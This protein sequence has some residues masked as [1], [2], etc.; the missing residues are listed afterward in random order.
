[1]VCI[2]ALLDKL[3]ET[4]QPRLVSNGFVCWLAYAQPLPNNFFQSLADMGGWSVVEDTNQSLW[5]FP[6]PNVLPGLG[7]LHNWARLHPMSTAITVFE[8][9]LAIDDHLQQSIRLPSNLLT[10]CV[11]YPKR[12]VIHVS[13]KLREL[14]R[15]MTN[16]IFKQ[17]QT[18]R[19][20][21]GEWFELEGG[22]LDPNAYTQSW[23]W[24]IRPQKGHQDKA[25]VKGW[26]NYGDRLEALFHQLKIPYLKTEDQ[27]LVLKISS[28]R[29]L[30]QFINKLFEF[31]GD[32][33]NL[34]WPCQYMGLEIGSHSFSTEFP[35]KVRHLFDPLEIGA[36][37]LSL[38]TVFQI[39]NPQIIPVDSR[40]SLT[41]SKI[42]DLYQIQLHPQAGG[43]R[44]G[45]LNIFL[46]SALVSG[47]EY[48]CFYC[49][50][51]SHLPANCPSRIL[52]PGNIKITALSRLGRINLDELPKILAEIEKQLSSNI[53]PGL[54]NLLMEKNDLGNV[55]AS[56]FE[57]NMICQ[58]RMVA[59]VLRAKG[60]EWPHGIENLRPQNEEYLWDAFNALR[61]GH[62]ER[63]REKLD[64][65]VLQS[66][67]S[68]QVRVLYG[69]LALERGEPRRAASF[70]EEAER[71][72]YT[73]LQ[74]SYLQLLRARLSETSNNLAEAMRLYDRAYKNSPGLSQARYRQA[75][76]MV[77]SGYLNEAQATMRDLIEGD[78]D[79][80]SI[81]LLD[82]ELEPARSF[83]L[84]DLWEIWD[85]VQTKA[86]EIIGAV[87]H[88]PDLL[89]SWL[90]PDHNNYTMLRKRIDELNTH[91]GINNY[92]ATARL[93][94]GAITI[95]NEIQAKV[96]KD[97]QKL[98]AKRKLMQKRL[99]KIRREASWF[100]FPAMLGRFTRMF[101][102][103]ADNL[104]NL[105]H[106]DL[107]VPSRFRQGHEIM[108]SAENLLAK[109]EKKLL[110]LQVIRNSILY[111]LLFFRYFIGYEI[112][113]LLLASGLTL[114]LNFVDF[115]PAIMGRTFSQ[116]KLAIFN[117]LLIVLSFAAMALTAI[118]TTSKFEKHKERILN[119][120]SP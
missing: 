108:R 89:T 12:L 65:F 94:Q 77:K 86:Q 19:G 71:L 45:S 104:E 1:M 21:T 112:L 32:T 88:L 13:D 57:I 51:R 43:K 59:M 49:G 30:D 103:C 76:C 50:L 72:A 27:A 9:S 118:T 106:M 64:R 23:L 33:Q 114:S 2:K 42:T 36:L 4:G 56:L 81:V 8:S 113:A 73:G 95:R 58:L 3:P 74:R 55:V 101:N 61:L 15:S 102:Q 120:K 35:S 68:Y 34:A 29:I 22:E 83:F 93:L 17:V 31:L 48:P 10:L 110:M 14:S 85:Q 84:S 5:F 98:T 115:G 60:K 90:P 97:I 20:F 41:S 7:K 105:S 109:I 25:F 37:Y 53:L 26:K 39:A 78:P 11:E 119:K 117:M 100:P 70:W 82:P 46:P 69:F 107:Y 40:A 111:A 38:S 96:K 44:R 91:A 66:S 63:A 67:K 99:G 79:Y 18:P 52:E 47:A 116:D 92:V 62:P 54:S 87:E 75:V 24:L 16:L 80:F 6:S 28:V